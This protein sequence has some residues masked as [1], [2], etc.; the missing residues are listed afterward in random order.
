MY[1]PRPFTTTLT[2][3]LLL[4]STAFAGCDS[5]TDRSPKG[6]LSSDQLTNNP[7]GVEALVRAAYA[8]LDGA[9]T[10]G[11]DI[12]IFTFFNPPSNWSYS[13]VRSDNAYKGGG[14]TGDIG[15]YHV[16]EINNGLT[17]TNFTINRK[18]E[19]DFQGVMRANEAIRALQEISDE[20]LPNK[21]QRIAEMRFLRGHFYFDLIKLFRH[22]PWI[23]ETV[24][25]QEVADISNTE[26]T[27][28]EL[29][30]NVRGDFQFAS[31]NLPDQ[32]AEPARADRFAAEAYLAKVALFRE[33]WGE[34]INHADA[35]IN[36][37]NFG[38]LENYSDLSK[39][40]T[41][42]H[43]K[44]DIFSIPFSVNDGSDLGNINWG[45]LLNMP[46]TDACGGGGDG[47]LRPSQN[48]VNA[49][50]VDE[51]GLPLFDT[52]N[53]EDVSPSNPPGDDTPVDPRLDLVVTRLG[54]PWKEFHTTQAGQRSASPIPDSSWMRQAQ[55]YGVYARKKLIVPPDSPFKVEGFPWCGSPLNFPLIRYAEILLWKAEALVE[56]GQDIE[57]ARQLVNQVRER[58]AN[59]DSWVREVNGNDFA[60]NYNIGLYSSSE[61]TTNTARKAVRFELRLETALEGHRF[62]NLVRWGIA[63]DAL[64]EYFE[65]EEDNASYYSGATFQE[66]VHEVLPIPQT[67]I[68]ISEGVYEQN[69]GY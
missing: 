23:D 46:T 18:W 47:F 57:A 33:N 44:E 11:E 60:A 3:A 26:L 31:E 55:T 22:V 6:T 53:D 4:L 62:F 61:W 67:Q 54:I 27:V 65:E 32:T 1:L 15:E 69:S 17:P 2:L 14:G 58:A 36:S 16:M 37:N 43:G 66:G 59:E 51:D 45:D 56:S 19:S 41:F 63:D 21:Q 50:K 49:Y 48:L 40:E 7:E 10:T 39:V 38:L 12:Q 34:V 24:S 5:F 42:D 29:W 13:E 64:T 9:I 52:F 35:V 68:D 28:N 20:E 30:D 8:S 25:P